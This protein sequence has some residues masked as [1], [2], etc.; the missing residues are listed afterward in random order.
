MGEL[1][2]DHA[3]DFLAREHLQQAGRRRHRRV[4][5]VAS[6]CECIGLR[7]VHEIDPRHG[8]AG[9]AGEILHEVHEVGGRGLVDLMGVVHRQHQLVRIPVAGEVHAGG[10][11]E[12]DHGAACAADEVADPHEQGGEPGQ[13]NGGTQIVHGSL[14]RGEPRAQ[15]LR[16]ATGSTLCIKCWVGRVRLPEPLC[17]ATRQA[18]IGA[19]QAGDI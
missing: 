5:G 4:L 6:G 12:R 1:V 18:L 10:D 2:G 11:E 13:Q 3:G 16:A 7:I 8:Q 19:R 9:A 14:P 17:R 15:R